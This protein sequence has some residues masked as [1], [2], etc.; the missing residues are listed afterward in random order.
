MLPLLRAAQWSDHADRVRCGWGTTARLS[1]RSTFDPLARELP[2]SASISPEVSRAPSAVG[3]G[4]CLLWPVAEP[5]EGLD[6]CTGTSRSVA[7]VQPII[8]YS[9]SEVERSAGGSQGASRLASVL[10]RLGRLLISTG[11]VTLAFVA[12]QLWGTGLLQARAQSGLESEFAALQ[13]EVV[14]QPANPVSTDAAD[15]DTPTPVETAD[16]TPPQATSSPT[17]TPVPTPPAIN[18]IPQRAVDRD[19]GEVVGRLLI[20]RIGLDQFVVEGVGAEELKEGPGHYRGT[21]MPGMAGNAGLAG[22]RTTWGAPFHRIDELMPGDEIT[23]VMPWGDAVY[24]VIGH[25]AGD[26]SE[27]GYFV[28]A[29]S[30]VWVLDQDGEDRLTLTSC[31]PKYS[32]RQRI[33]VTARLVSEPVQVAGPVLAAEPPPLPELAREDV[34]SQPLLGEGAQVAAAPTE[35]PIEPTTGRSEPDLSTSNAAPVAG[36]QGAVEGGEASFGSGLSGDRSSI[37]PSITWGMAAIGMWWTAGF[38][39]RRWRPLVPYVVAAAP[40]AV[41]WFIAFAYIDQAIPS[42]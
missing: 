12:Y 24:E 30:D 5:R 42:Y 25:P 20:P 17:S 6:R 34:A 15:P 2:S 11:V 1:P 10:G 32:A 26:G 39:A 4:A 8:S 9:M 3:P 35:R 16:P 23:V 19:V 40:L 21:V 33:I 13:A 7:D 31:H 38:V 36:A 37:L 14:A 22:H 28:V 27:R 29:P 18:A 41:V